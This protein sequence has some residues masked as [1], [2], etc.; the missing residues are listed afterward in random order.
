[1]KKLTAGIFATILGLTAIDAYAAIPTQNYVDSAVG[2]VQATASTAA[3]NAADALD[4]ISKL[5]TTYVTEGELSGKGYATTGYVDNAT[6][7]MATQT[8]VGNEKFLKE[9]N[10][11][12]YAKT[13]DVVTNEEFATFEETNS[14]EIAAAKKA[15]TDAQATADANA[16]AI[17][18]L[19]TTYVTEGELSGK[20]YATTGYVDNA[21][22]DMATQTWVGNEKFLKEANLAGYAKTA[23]VV[24]NE[25]FTTFEANNT[26]AIADAKLAGTNAQKTAN[27]ALQGAEAANNVIGTLK[28]AAYTESNAYATAAQG[29]KADTALQKVAC[30]NPDGC[31][32]MAD[33]TIV[34]LVNT[35]NGQQM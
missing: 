31:V 16:L 19:D 27:E 33:G 29:E 11:A 25:E 18:N 20:G 34:E 3:M 14:L 32:L 23:D 8:W 1:M 22:N 24:T 30:S 17:Q 9:A 7:D 4:K 26:A 12:G 28:S 15:G 5:D 2:S 6:N 21:T 35:Y 10:L 13:A